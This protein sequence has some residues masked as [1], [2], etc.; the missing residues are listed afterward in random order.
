[1]EKI[2]HL[3]DGAYAEFDGYGIMLRANSHTAPTGVYLEPIVLESL[4][5]FAKTHKVIKE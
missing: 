2:V 3:G 4:I 5:S 1:M